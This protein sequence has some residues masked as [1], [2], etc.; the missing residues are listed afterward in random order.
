MPCERRIKRLYVFQ[1]EQGARLVQQ[2]E[3]QPFAEGRRHHRDADVDFTI[4]DANGD[5]PVLWQAPFG[6]IE[7]GHDFQARRDGRLQALWRR[8]HFV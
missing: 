7:R 4:A 8:Q 5:A 3:D 2:T 6:N 1:F